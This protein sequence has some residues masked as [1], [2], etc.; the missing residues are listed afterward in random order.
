MD[1]K[2]IIRRKSEKKDVVI[3]LRVTTPQSKWLKEKNYSPN[4]IFQEALLDLQKVNKD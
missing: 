1:M 2:K 4:D 3:T